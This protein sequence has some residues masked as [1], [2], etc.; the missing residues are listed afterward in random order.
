MSYKLVLEE[1]INVPNYIVPKYLIT[2]NSRG[3][4]TSIVK[5]LCCDEYFEY[6]KLIP[7]KFII[8]TTD[9][10]L[11]ECAKNGSIIGTEYIWKVSEKKITITHLIFLLRQN[12]E[13]FK[14]I[15]YDGK[16]ISLNENLD[17]LEWILNFKEL[18]TKIEDIN[19]LESCIMKDNLKIFLKLYYSFNFINTSD[20]LDNL[21]IY[22]YT[23]GKIKFCEVIYEI[24]LQ[25]Y[26][27]DNKLNNLEAKLYNIFKNSR[28]E[29][30]NFECFEWIYD[31]IKSKV[32][33]N[34]LKSIYMI[35]CYNFEIINFIE[36][37]LKISHGDMKKKLDEFIKFVSYMGDTTDYLKIYIH[38]V[39]KLNLNINEKQNLFN[40]IEKKRYN[41]DIFKQIGNYL[42]D[43]GVEVSSFKSRYYQYYNNK[44]QIQLKKIR[45]SYKEENDSYYLIGDTIENKICL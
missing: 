37:K 4:I 22:A 32:T 3:V 19:I 29:Q 21:L 43:E 12:I 26:N 23:H 36:S 30:I 41:Y 17:Y 33:D 14:T 38:L 44:K 15:I 31:K 39:N 7:D 34:E 11:A 5:E 2:N 8:S 6:L 25:N 40:E 18:K 16:E 35:N 1:W 13:R 42:I 24:I 28:T 9:T 10:L 27:N 45:Q 20:I